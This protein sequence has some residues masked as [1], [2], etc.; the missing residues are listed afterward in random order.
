MV[1]RLSARKRCKS[2][3]E[4]ATAQG[5]KVNM[6]GNKGDAQEN[7]ANVQGTGVSVQVPSCLGPQPP[8]VW[9]PAAV[10]IVTI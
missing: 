5:N 10:S 4:R 8:S 2:R 1:C 9:A 3:V 6:F 7:G